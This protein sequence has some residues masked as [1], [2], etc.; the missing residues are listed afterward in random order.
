MPSLQ[1]RLSYPPSARPEDKPAAPRLEERIGRPANPPSLEERISNPPAADSRPIRPPADDRLPPRQ[2]LPSDRPVP[3]AGDDRSVLAEPARPPPPLVERPPPSS[4]D[5]HYPPPGR[6]T[7][8]PSPAASERGRPYRAPSVARDEPRPYRLRSPSRPPSRSDARDYR[9][10]ADGRDRLDPRPPYRPDP[11][12]YERRADIMDVDPPPR[13]SDTR[14][15]YRRPSPPPGESYSRDRTWVPAGEA[16]P[17]RD[18]EPSRRP[19]TDYPREWREGDRPPYGE[20]FDRSWDRPREYERDGRFPPPDR[21]GPPA[22]WEARDERDRRAAYP[23][24]DLPPS[25]SRS[26]DPPRPLSSRL[27]DSYADDRGYARDHDR[28]RYPPPPPP[29]AD[30]P[31]YSRVRP[32]S[33][34]PVRRTA[35]GDDPRPPLKRPRDDAYPSGGFYPDEARGP[36]EYPPPRLRSPPPAGGGYYDDPRYNTSPGAG[37]DR[38]YLSSRDRDGAYG[39]DRR[40]DPPGRMPPPRS[41]PPYAR[42]VYDRDDRRFPP[43]P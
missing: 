6:F 4:D 27:T 36:S 14:A 23:P 8:P 18:S 20:D 7:R 3:R 25:A 31:S 11:D 16:P 24:A 5:R 17:Y 29:P 33:P 22:G 28:A 34:S 21:D 42:S 37:R 38:E 15:S 26:Y 19:T 32:R 35:P 13:F 39:Y 10:P 41:P 30:G 9:P 1:E 43:R 12:R 2:P 40:G